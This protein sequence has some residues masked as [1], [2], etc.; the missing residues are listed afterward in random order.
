MSTTSLL[1]HAFNLVHY[2]NIRT[3]FTEGKIIFHIQHKPNKLRCSNCKSK[4]YINKGKIRRMFKTVPIGKK[5]MLFKAGH[6][7]FKM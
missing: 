2:L 4:D 7:A 3:E 6:T 5:R 1:Y